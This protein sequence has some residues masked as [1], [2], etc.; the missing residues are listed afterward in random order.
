[1]DDPPGTIPQERQTPHPRRPPAHQSVSLRHSPPASG[2][3]PKAPTFYNPQ[4]TAVSSPNVGASDKANPPS[5][6]S[7][8][9]KSNKNSSGESSDAGKWFENTNNAVQSNN[10]LDNDPPFFLRNSS[11]SETP[12][13]GQAF[14][15]LYQH[16]TAAMPYRPGIGNMNNESV[17]DFRSVIDDLTVANK[18]LKQKLRKYEKLHDSHLQDEKLFEVRFHGLPDH[19]K[20]ELE[21]TLRKFAADMDSKS[22]QD[23]PAVST[24]PAMFENQKTAS[25]RASRFAESGYASMSGHNSNSARS[26]Q[27]S[28][29]ASNTDWDQRRLTKMNYNQQQQ[30]IQSY[31]HDIPRGLLPKS[32]HAPMSDKSK[33]KLVVR[34]L[35]QIFAGKRSAPG[36]HPQPMQ[37]EEVAQSAAT[38]DRRANEAA[39]QRSK[40][41]GHREARIMPV[42]ADDEDI[43]G[44]QEALQ[45]SRL[46]LQINEQDFA[47]SGSPD[48]RPTRPLDLD[49]Y[50]A[51]V[52]SDNM[53]YIRHLGFTPPNMMSEGSPE[54]DHGWIYLNLLINMAQLH[55]LNVTPDFVKDAVSEYSSLFELSHDGRKIRWR[56]GTDVTLSSTGSS[57][58]YQGNSPPDG[59][60]NSKS[61]HRFAKTGGSGSSDLSMN[62][63]RVAQRLARKQKEKERNQFSYTPLFF[64]KDDSDDEEDSYGLDMNSSSNS[65]YQVQ[66]AGDSSGLGSSAKQSS[67]SKRRRNDGPIIF[68]SKAKF[69]TDLTGDSRGIASHTSDSYQN[70]TSHPIGV[71]TSHPGRLIQSSSVMERRG[72]LETTMMDIDSKDGSQTA[73]SSEEFSFSPDALNDDNGT[74]SPDVMDFEASGLGGVHPEDNFSIRVRRSQQQAAPTSVVAARHRSSLYPKKILDVLNESPTQEDNPTSPKQQQSVIKE[75]IISASRRTLPNSALPPAS[76]LPFDSTSSGDVDSDLESNVSSSLSSTSSSENVPATALHLLNVSSVQR[77]FS[78]ASGDSSS[79]GDDEDD[80]DDGSIDLL[81]TARRMDPHTVIASEREYDAALADRLVEEIPAGSSA[82][83]AGG[84]SGFNTPANALEALTEQGEP[85]GRTSRQKRQSTTSGSLSSQAR[86]KL[87]RNRTRESIATALQETSKRAKTQKR[88]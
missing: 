5:S 63:E 24:H 56:G 86:A 51:Q 18:R 32:H 84:G 55:T 3:P 35:E 80:S 11:P 27:P 78:D 50:R 52:P 17:E 13:D 36:N 40:T 64:H 37:Q 43:S 1:M 68:Y 20:R 76:F 83:T 21:E 87:K 57:S 19:K 2:V 58:E 69:C 74:E 88:E 29:T 70:I 47:G 7:P 53:D 12:P 44:H 39:G 82:A 4:A 26:N 16:T 59:Y 33:K 61:P 49:I 14:D 60:G 6:V 23:Y 71:P 10:N 85:T 81:A 41:E 15:H 30:T 42:R 75:E 28:N 79:E 54:D 46:N 66:Q 9:V 25:S 73:S 31:L 48:Q 67:A 72:P 77:D 8:Q 34:R 38:A 45:K 22:E 62:P 65:P